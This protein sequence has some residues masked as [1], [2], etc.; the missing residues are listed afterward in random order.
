MDRL[1]QGSVEE[2]AEGFAEDGDSSQM[3]ERL[4]W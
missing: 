3:F 2:D 4:S 1:A